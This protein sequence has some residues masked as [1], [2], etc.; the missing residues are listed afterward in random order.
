MY[1]YVCV[2]VY[3]L[4]TLIQVCN[5]EEFLHLVTESGKKSILSFTY[6]YKN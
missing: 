2:R 5:L 3:K 4:D 6:L 1:I